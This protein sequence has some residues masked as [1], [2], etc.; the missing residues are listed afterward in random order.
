VLLLLKR[1]SFIGEIYIYIIFIICSNYRSRKYLMKEKYVT[2]K[3]LLDFLNI[4]IFDIHW[5]FKIIAEVSFIEV[6]QTIYLI[7]ILANS[8]YINWKNILLSLFQLLTTVS[9]YIVVDIL[10]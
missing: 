2:N 6:P 7:K 3:R 5:S 4:I 8:I 1:N 10:Y 9:R